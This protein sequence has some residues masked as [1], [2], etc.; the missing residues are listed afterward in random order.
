[1]LG[2][3]AGALCS[4]AF[5]KVAWAT[6][7]CE[8]K[9]TRRMTLA[10]TELAAESVHQGGHCRCHWPAC[11]LHSL[12]KKSRS[13]TLFRPILSA[14]PSFLLQST[15]HTSFFFPIFGWRC[16]RF[17]LA[18]ANKQQGVQNNTKEDSSEHFRHAAY[19]SSL[20]SKSGNILVKTAA[21]RINLNLDGATIGSKSH[22]DPS[23]PE[24]SRLLTSS[25]SLGVPV[26]R[27]TQ[28]MR[29]T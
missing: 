3:S 10:I 16:V 25:L 24:T 17:I 26:P 13:S 19:F 9:C 6:L 2:K 1:M 7:G 20:K 5:V 11:H 28:C 4:L 21:L 27:P 23:H 14:F 12:D 15:T 29:V 22:T 18:F 8:G